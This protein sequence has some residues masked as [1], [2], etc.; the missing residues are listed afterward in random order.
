MSLGCAL[1]V[2]RHAG[3]VVANDDYVN[4]GVVFRILLLIVR[5]LIRVRSIIDGSCVPRYFVMISPGFNNAV[6]PLQAVLI[7]LIVVQRT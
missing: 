2:A 1:F 6:T 5:V 3:G 7:V 4:T